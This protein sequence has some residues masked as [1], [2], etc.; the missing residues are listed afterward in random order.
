MW[1]AT[2]SPCSRPR[3]TPWPKE[4][5]ELWYSECCT[6]RKRLSSRFGRGAW[7]EVIQEPSAW[8]RGWTWGVGERSSLLVLLVSGHELPGENVFSWTTLGNSRVE[9]VRVCTLA[10]WDRQFQP[11]CFVPPN[12]RPSTSELGSMMFP[13]L[14]MMDSKTRLVQES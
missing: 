13:V 11:R 14:E 3:F 12:E 2:G 5:T 10:L 6:S 7:L 8:L 4:S 9:G 1:P